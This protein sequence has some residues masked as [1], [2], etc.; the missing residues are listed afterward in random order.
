VIQVK[1][2]NKYYDNHKAVDGVS[3]TVKKGEILGFLGPNGAGKTTT[4]NILSGFLQPTSGTALINGFDVIQQSLQAKS[5]IGYL[6]EIPPVYPTMLVY[7]YLNFAARLHG[8]SK[9][10]KNKAVATAIE[11][12]GLGDVRSRL[13]GNLSKGFRQRVGLAQA[14]AHDPEILILDEP[15]VGLDP[16]QII[17][18]RKMIHDLAGDHTVILSTHILPEVQATCQRVVVIDGGKVVAENTLNGIVDQMS[19]SSRLHI[20][21]QKSPLASFIEKLKKIDGVVLV[22]AQSKQNADFYELTVECKKGVD[23]RAQI[24]E[25]I[26]H[27][28]LGL[29]FLSEEHLSLEAAFVKLVSQDREANYQ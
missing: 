2:I 11:K 8:V 22:N 16:K 19:V 14:I 10:N 6:P 9:E 17:E 12:C 28:K 1:Q 5:C 29:L 18:I 15:T 7:E 13:I 23:L 20:K 26:V 24:A 3:F 4:M 25:N 27:E 21:L